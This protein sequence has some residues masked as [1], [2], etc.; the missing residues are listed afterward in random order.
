MKKVL[1]SFITL[2]GI[3]LLVSCGSDTNSKI[4]SNEMEQDLNATQSIEDEKELAKIALI[5]GRGTIDDKSFNQGTWEGISK[6]ASPKGINH[7]F[8]QTKASTTEAYFETIEEAIKS[9]ANLV[10]CP[11]YSFEES[12]Y[13]A[14]DKYPYVNFILLD[15]EPHDADN[16]EY[17][18]A[19]N[20]MAILYQEDQSGFLAGYAAVKDGYTKLGFIGGEK[21]PSVIRYGMG[22]IQGIDV[23]AKELGVNCEVKYNYTGQ[24]AEAPETKNLATSWYDSGTEVI[25]GCGGSLGNSIMS[26]AEEKNKTENSFV[27]KVIGVD[28]DQYSESNTVITSAIKMLS[29]SVYDAIDMYYSGK[30]P[31]GKTT[32]FNVKND[33]VGIAM[34]HSKFTTFT[35]SDYNLLYENLKKDK[36]D[37]ND[38][39]TEINPNKAEL[40][41]VNTEVIFI[42]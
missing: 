8:Y 18:V 19:A 1:Y 3:L 35:E 15:G 38:E 31:S 26:A 39:M 41:L 32:I 22:F 13:L 28:V 20:T 6:Y 17:K 33:G 21:V 16:K 27:A 4:M 23:A 14:Q 34:E 11:G 2:I 29:N 9:G 37:I 40:G 10:V 5:T 42:Q 24:F 30:F 36:Y 7:K 12:V 25:F